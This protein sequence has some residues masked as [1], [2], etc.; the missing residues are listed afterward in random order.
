[1]AVVEADFGH[2]VYRSAGN[3]VAVF[4]VAVHTLRHHTNGSPV[5]PTVTG[6]AKL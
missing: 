3:I 2:R 4:S 5:S 1:M 6:R